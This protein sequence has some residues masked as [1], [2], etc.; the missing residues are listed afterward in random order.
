MDINNYFEGLGTELISIIVGL[1]MGGGAFVY[2]KNGKV[3]QKQKAGSNAK[4]KQEVK[5]SD[6]KDVYQEQVAGD[7]SE[8]TQIG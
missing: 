8:Q 5:N 1:L 7:N 4:Q 3:S 2:Y 6:G